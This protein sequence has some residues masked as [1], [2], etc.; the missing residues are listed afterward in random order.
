LLVAGFARHSFS[1]G[2][3]LVPGSCCQLHTAN[4]QLNHNKQPIEWFKLDCRKTPVWIIFCILKIELNKNN[5]SQIR[6]IHFIFK[7]ALI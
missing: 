2:G 5:G 4:C 1:G 7:K 6:M 3:L